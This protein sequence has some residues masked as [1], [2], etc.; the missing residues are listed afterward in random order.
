M[1]MSGEVAEIHMRTDAKNLVTTARTIHLLEQKETTHMISMLRN[2][3][4]PAS[5]HDFAHISTQNCLF[6]CLTKLSAKADKLITAV[7]TVRLWEVD[8]H[9]NFRTL[10]DDMA[11]LST[12]YRTFMH[13]REKNASS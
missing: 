5:V 13:T 6:V 11:F 12:W 8:V 9:P 1:D 10:M 7:E 4:C 3:T 2:E